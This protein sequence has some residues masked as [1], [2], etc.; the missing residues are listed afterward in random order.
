MGVNYIQYNEL[1]PLYNH[2]NFMSTVSIVGLNGTEKTSS[3][4]FTDLIP[5]G[6]KELIQVKLLSTRDVR[7]PQCQRGNR[8]QWRL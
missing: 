1:S 7:K 3:P 2:I 6:L 8:E 5:V 4:D